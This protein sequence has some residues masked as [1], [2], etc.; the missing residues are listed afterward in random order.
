MRPDPPTKSATAEELLS[1][2]GLLKDLKKRLIES[3][4]EAEMTDHL[5]YEKHAIDGRGTGSS[6]NGRSGCLAS[7]RRCCR[8]TPVT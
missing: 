3:A 1:D 5:G 4:L 2:S 6:R 8:C 7:T